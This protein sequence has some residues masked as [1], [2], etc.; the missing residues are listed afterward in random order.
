MAQ[1]LR[2]ARGSRSKRSVYNELGVSAQTYELW[3]R[4][5]YVPSDEH[6]EQLADFL[7]MEL[8]DV[9]WTLYKDRVTPIIHVMP[10]VTTS[11]ADMPLERVLGSVVAA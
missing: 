7:C 2:R 4:G 9:V 1:L 5:V 6:A 8:R 10:K 3:E 11:L